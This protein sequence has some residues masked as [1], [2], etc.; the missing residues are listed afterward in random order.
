MALCLSLV[1][2]Q[3]F[4]LGRAPQAAVLAAMPQFLRRLKLKGLMAS[5]GGK[6]FM[7]ERIS[8]RQSATSLLGA[9]AKAGVW[10][11]K[12]RETQISTTQSSATKYILRTVLDV[13]CNKWGIRH[14]SVSSILHSL[15]FFGT[16]KNVEQKPENFWFPETFLIAPTAMRCLMAW[17][18]CFLGRWDLGEE[19]VIHRNGS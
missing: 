13:S 8:A 17:R 2:G 9:Q 3:L 18:L 4:P 7:V 1:Y 6:G 12:E 5:L 10:P 15:F 11:V 19:K 14:A 16:K